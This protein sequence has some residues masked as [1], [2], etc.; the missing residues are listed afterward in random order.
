MTPAMPTAQTARPRKR[1]QWWLFRLLQR[2]A[3]LKSGLMPPVP[4]KQ[5]QGPALWVFASTIGELNA[6]SVYIDALLQRSAGLN[7]VLLTDHEHYREAYL[8]RYPSAKLHL[9]SAHPAAAETLAHTHPPRFLVLAEIPCLP[10]DAPCR[11]PVNYAFAAK[12]AGARLAL[13]NA[14]FYDGSP[15]CRMDAIEQAWFSADYLAAFD[16]IG[17]QTDA[18]AQ[19]LLDIGAKA[20]SIA[21]TGNLKF[22]GLQ[23]RPTEAE[24]AGRSSLLASLLAQKRPIIVAGCVT[25][26]EEQPLVLDA[27]ATLRQ[28]HPDALLVI[29]PRHPE[30]ADRMAKLTD[31]LNERHLPYASRR[32]LGEA[33]VPPEA[34]CLVLDTIGELRDFYAA[35][36]I[37]HVGVNHNALE[38]LSFH[39]PVTVI[40]GWL[41]S[42]AS[43]PVY[44]LLIER[45]CLH[46]VNDSQELSKLWCNLLDDEPRYRDEVRRINASLQEFSGATERNLSL[47][48]NAASGDR[49]TP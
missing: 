14:W 17:A 25:S 2:L 35:A 5:A 8:R 11:F 44:C 43:Y 18:V 23:A 22:D 41:P 49:G 9:C 48:L 40:P 1:L 45:Q 19:R 6:A 29:A 42:Y 12:A 26:Y 37:A 32:A 21:V 15:S 30:M 31:F 38:P 34:A 13:V 3:A 10:A 36:S 7:L 16:A 27:F 47:L 39:K 28:R 46:Q 20:S 4:S 33:P 24:L